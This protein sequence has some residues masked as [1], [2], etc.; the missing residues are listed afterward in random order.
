M[1][2]LFEQKQNL[3]FE[4]RTMYTVLKKIYEKTPCLICISGKIR[5]G[6]SCACLALIKFN[7]QMKRFDDIVVV[8]S[9]IHS[10]FW[11]KNGIPIQ[12]QYEKLDQ[13]MLNALREHQ[14]KTNKKRSV[15]LV[16]DDCIDSANMYDKGLVSFLTVLRHFNTTVVVITQ[17]ITKISPVIRSNCDFMILFQLIG[18][19]ALKTLFDELSM[20]ESRSQFVADFIER[21]KDYGALFINNTTANL[22]D[23]ISTLKINCRVLGIKF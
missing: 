18:E 9:T 19:K 20:G 22:A 4:I 23:R 5:S 17:S 15:M 10:N 2:S 1:T 21:T 14:I 6:K 7:K 13:Q 3:K 8:S 12:S 11:T 16:I